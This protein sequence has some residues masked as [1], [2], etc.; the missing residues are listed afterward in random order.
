MVLFLQVLLLLFVG[1]VECSPLLRG[2][3][4]RAKKII[5]FWQ[6]PRFVV[7]NI[8]ETSQHLSVLD[9]SLAIF[10]LLCFIRPMKGDSFPGNRIK[11]KCGS[12]IVD[13]LIVRF[14]LLIENHRIDS[15]IT[16]GHL[17]LILL[18]LQNK[19]K[20][21]LL[22]KQ[23]HKYCEG[24]ACWMLFEILETERTLESVC[25]MTF[26]DYGSDT[27]EKGQSRTPAPTPTVNKCQ[28]SW[29]LFVI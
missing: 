26:N 5:L 18:S 9:S 11:L 28:S 13:V 16:T 27:Y 10:D 1:R 21:L 3:W 24:D 23:D 14:L 20:I 29:A 8:E 6:Y 12:G 15:I 17:I 19:R 22:P 7:V 4:F 25:T 2:R